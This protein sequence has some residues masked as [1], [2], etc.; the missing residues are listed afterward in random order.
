MT[1]STGNSKR[2]DSDCNSDGWKKDYTKA[3][4]MYIVRRLGQADDDNISDDARKLGKE[5]KKAYKRLKSSHWGKT[6]RTTKRT[7]SVQLEA[8]LEI[9]MEQEK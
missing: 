8:A 9:P 6:Q 2:Y 7:P 4:Q 3:E 5:A 1:G